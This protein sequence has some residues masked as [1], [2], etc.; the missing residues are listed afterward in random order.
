M[1]TQKI[2]SVAQTGAESILWLLIALSVISLG[3]IFERFLVLRQ[4]R[5]NSEKVLVKIKDSLQSNSLS[6]IEEIAKDKEALEGKALCYGLRHIQAN[7]K[8]GLE[9]VFNTFALSEKPG[10]EKN[11]NFLAT[12]GSNAPFIG[13]LGTVLEIMR[14]ISTLG[15]SQGDMSGVI[16]GI[17][18]AL[19][20]TAVGLFVAIPAVVAFNHFSKQV[21]GTLQGLETVREYCAAYAKSSKVVANG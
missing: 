9:E 10:L 14:A 4:T 20:A 11:L 1:L 16:V 18:G 17:A 2:F 21:K 3:I 19:V 5:K 6:D 15:A 12:V 7:G 8:E 13:L